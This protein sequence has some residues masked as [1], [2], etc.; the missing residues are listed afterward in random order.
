M[1]SGYKMGVLPVEID[2]RYLNYCDV[3]KYWDT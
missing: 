2:P 1:N 3:P